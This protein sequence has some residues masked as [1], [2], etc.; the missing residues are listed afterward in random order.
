MRKINRI[1]IHATATIEGKEYDV[2]EI[3]KWHT[4]P[5]KLGGRGFN[6][7]GY[8][9]LILLNG[10][11]ETGRP[12]EKP[13][14]HTKGYNSDSIGISYV[15]G[16]D[17]DGKPKDTR[18]QEQKDGMQKLVSYLKL[19]YPTITEIKGHRDYSPDLDKD[20]I[21]EPNEWIKICPCFEVS[22]EFKN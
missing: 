4:T 21:I 6:D 10:H 1:I 9:Y 2:E 19:Q 8:H 11:F 3:R 5:I 13:G 16:L 15:G 7:I 20:G 14:A 18:T 17:V 22:D 12:I